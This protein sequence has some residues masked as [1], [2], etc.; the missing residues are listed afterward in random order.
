VIR[1]NPTREIG[2][3]V[4]RISDFNWGDSNSNVTPVVGGLEQR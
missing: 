4:F 2:E 1:Y 3:V